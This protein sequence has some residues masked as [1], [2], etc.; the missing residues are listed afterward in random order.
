MKENAQ[1][2]KNIY[3]YFFSYLW[4]KKGSSAVNTNVLSQ[5]PLHQNTELGIQSKEIVIDLPGTFKRATIKNTNKQYSKMTF[6]LISNLCNAHSS[7][8][9]IIP[10]TLI[11]RKLPQSVWYLE[12]IVFIGTWIVIFNLLFIWIL[13]MLIAF[14]I[15]VSWKSQV[16]VLLSFS[17]N[18]SLL[19]CWI[20]CVP[21]YLI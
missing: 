12:F 2:T 10:C 9:K 17:L 7:K 20:S 4:T 14:K 19:W 21:I 8:K 5:L 18:I 13:K 15:C 11:K 16:L 6:L 3:T 1:N